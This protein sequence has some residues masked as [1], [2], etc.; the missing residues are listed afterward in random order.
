MKLRLNRLIS[1]CA[2]FLVFGA[3]SFLV[4]QTPSKIPSYAF[5]PNEELVLGVEFSRS[6][7]KNVDVAEFRFTSNSDASSGS[8]SGLPYSI[9][10]TGEVTS[11]G[12]F[13]RIF[14]LK[15]REWMESEVEPA[16]FTVSRSKRID[17]QGKRVRISEAVFADGKVSWTERDPNNPSSTPRTADAPF[18]GQ[19]QD[20]L[21][22]IYFL[23]TQPLIP[24]RTLE[25]TI[26]DSGRVYK[27]PVR[28]VEKKRFKTVLG[29][30]DAVRV[31]P[32]LFGPDGLMTRE[33]HISIWYTNDSRRVPVKAKIKT[34][35]G[36]FNVSL[37]KMTQRPTPQPQAASN[38]GSSRLGT[39]P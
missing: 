3:T 34:E 8:Q 5:E 17:E 35:Y 28:V 30:V 9:K 7:L 36:T 10:L 32:G 22:A 1:S 11:K 27:I 13:A 38:S 16:L 18:T 39:A 21:S 31:D 25:V 14:N 37:R 15:F 29:K 12:F 26:S 33:A 2:L 6:L 20:I 19:I 4:A 24:G 23:R